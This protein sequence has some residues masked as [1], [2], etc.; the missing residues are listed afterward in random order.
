[1]FGMLKSLMRPIASIGEKVSGGLG[2]IGRKILPVMDKV[3]GFLGET[4]T[5]VDNLRKFAMKQ[6]GKSNRYS[7]S[8]V[9]N[10]GKKSK[11]IR[12]SGKNSRKQRKS[13]KGNTNS[14]KS[15]R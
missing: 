7:N 2:G 6:Y 14:R 10:N 9:G 12:T 4:L 3:G 8:K 15:I 1:M 5:N 13:N 11:T